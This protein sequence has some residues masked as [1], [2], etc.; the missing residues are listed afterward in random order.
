MAFLVLLE[1][2]GPEERAAFLLREVF[3]ASYD[4][5]ARI[6]DKTEPAVRQTVHRAK[7]RVR[8]GRPRLAP[9]P[10][11]EL[12]PDKLAHLR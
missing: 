6:L 12:E 5:I 9:P 11:Q 10:E 7:T 3:D 8:E 1:R 2:L 4:E